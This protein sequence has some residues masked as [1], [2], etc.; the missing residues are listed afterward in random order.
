MLCVKDKI[1]MYTIRE[2]KSRTF[3]SADPLAHPDGWNNFAYCNGRVTS[4]FPLNDMTVAF[5][6][7][8]AASGAYARPSLLS[9]VLFNELTIRQF[10]RFRFLRHSAK[11][12]RFK[13]H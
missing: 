1:H 5:T 12:G 10:I 7:L 6:H 2:K 11:G 9:G 4:G 8:F 13:Y 3:F